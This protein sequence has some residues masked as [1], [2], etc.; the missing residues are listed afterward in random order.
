ML[1]KLSA[2]T[3]SLFHPAD[4]KATPGIDN[5]TVFGLLLLLLC[6]IKLYF[7]IQQA[8]DVQF[9][10]EA[11]YIRFGLD[12][13]E[14]MNRNWGPMYSLWY[15]C[16]SFITTDTLQLYYLNFVISSVLIGILIYFFLRRLSVDNTFALF[17]S[18]SVLISDLNISVWPRIS[19]FCI[20]LCLAALIIISYLKNN[21]YRCMVFTIAC[22]INSYARPEFYLSFVLM[23]FITA[24]SAFFNRTSITRKNIALLAGSVL[25]IGVLHFIFRFPSNDFFGYNRGVAA[26]YQHYAWNYKMRTN[27]TFDA[28]LNWEDLAKKQFGDC[29][30]ILCVI[31]T[32]PGI[33]FGN[34][35]FNIRTYLLQL[36]KVFSYVFPVGIFHGKKLQLLLTVFTILTFFT[37]LFK[38]T[39]RSYFLE[40]I[41]SYRFYLLL[42]FCFIAPTLLSC[43]VVFPR[44]HYLY[45]QMPFMVLILISAFGFPF[46]YLSLKP[47]HLVLLGVLLLLATPNVQ[48]YSFMKVSTDTHSMCNKKLIQHLE[49][50]YGNE[51]HTLFTNM[52]FVR[53]LLPANFKEIN[54]IFDKKKHMPFTHYTDSAHIDIIIITPSTLRDPHIASDSNWIRFMKAPEKQGF[55]KEVFCDCDMYL[56]V[57]Q[58]A[59]TH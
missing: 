59:E 26:F 52:P 10:D 28:W 36:L 49:K 43:V 22:L 31:K 11:A 29:N 39:S 3:E 25:L 24:A 9:A 58:A 19:H 42:L 46:E 15:K 47:V 7:G 23:A 48:H 18:F 6:G 2:F 55:K 50:K 27:A 1:K 34:I 20:M 12:L 40:K 37:L 54:T 14:Q 16:L 38:K 45:L 5:N 30:S 53:G 44:D 35:L 33:F 32:Q 51:T 13:F 4:E 17:I 56:L 21:L 8:M 57:K 41:Y